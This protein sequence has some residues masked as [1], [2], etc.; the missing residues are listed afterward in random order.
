MVDVLT[1]IHNELAAIR[2]MVTVTNERVETL[3]SQQD[4]LIQTVDTLTASVD[5]L[6]LAL[7]N[8]KTQCLTS[9]H[10]EEAEIHELKQKLTDVASTMGT[11]VVNVHR[12]FALILGRVGPAF[13]QVERTVAPFANAV[14][15]LVDDA[16]MGGFV[17][18]QASD[19]VVW[20][21]ALQ[22]Q[23]N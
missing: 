11:A 13:E 22:Q 3:S 5:K 7:S 1:S 17:P 16:P 8:A 19:A 12:D 9:K 4:E 14:S 6:N 21:G 15:G 18:A 20:N 10:T 2:R 23:Q